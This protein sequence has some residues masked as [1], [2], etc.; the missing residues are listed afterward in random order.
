M[1]AFFEFR[2]DFTG[3]GGFSAA[4]LALDK[5]GDAVGALEHELS[6]DGFF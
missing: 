3:A 1:K 4:G 2:Y 5:G 6:K